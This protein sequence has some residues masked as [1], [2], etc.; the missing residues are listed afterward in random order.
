MGKKT[1]PLTKLRKANK[2][3][4]P[5]PLFHFSQISLLLPPKTQKQHNISWNSGSK[6]KNTN[7]IKPNKQPKK[8]LKKPAYPHLLP[9]DSPFSFFNLSLSSQNTTSTH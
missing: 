2:T 7:K 4:P 3:Q 1:Q 5:P 9:K 6:K 8:V